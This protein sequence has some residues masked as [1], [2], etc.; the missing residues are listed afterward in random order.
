MKKLTGKGNLIRRVEK[1]K[2]LGA[3]T[4]KNIDAKLLKRAE[5]DE[6]ED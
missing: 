4:S 6:S 3:K 1:L 5:D 2:K